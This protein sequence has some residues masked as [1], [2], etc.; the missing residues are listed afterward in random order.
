[1]LFSVLILIQ[2]G[3]GLQQAAAAAAAAAAATADTDISKP[4]FLVL[5]VDGRFIYR[6]NFN[7]GEKTISLLAVL[8]SGS[9]LTPISFSSESLFLFSLFSLL[10]FFLFLWDCFPS[11]FLLL[12]Y[13]Y[14]SFI[15]CRS[16]NESGP[17]S[18]STIWL[19]W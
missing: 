5:F 3:L 18:D 14:Y 2:L 16:W 8:F 4:N 13:E 12:I 19:L 9:Y 17:M 6:E 15:Y 7:Y 1:M 10:F 11:C